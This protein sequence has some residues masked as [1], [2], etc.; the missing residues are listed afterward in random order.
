[1]FRIDLPY[2]ARAHEQLV[3]QQYGRMASATAV[4][5]MASVGLEALGAARIEVDAVHVAPELYGYVIDLASASREHA[6][7]ALG[8]STRG[9][10]SL[11]RTARIHAALRGAEFVT[12]DDVKAM[13]PLVIPHRLVLATEALLE[14]VSE[15]AVAQRLLELVAVPK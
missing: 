6:H 2:P 1:M 10:L 12:P 13:V 9:A 8:L 3:L 15:L 11:L 4:G 7:V 5:E 14:G